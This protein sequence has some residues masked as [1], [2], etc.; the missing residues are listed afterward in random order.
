M[1]TKTRT[2]YLK[3]KSHFLIDQPKTC[4]IFMLRCIKSIFF[5]QSSNKLLQRKFK[6]LYFC[7]IEPNF[8]ETVDLVLEYKAFVQINEINK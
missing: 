5:N 7:E 6:M 3:K 2:T 8:I 1:K 4:R